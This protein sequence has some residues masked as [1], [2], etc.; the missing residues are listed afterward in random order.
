[1]ND[2]RTVILDHWWMNTQDVSLH[3][4]HDTV[5]QL[6]CLINLLKWECKVNR[7]HAIYVSQWD[8]L[9]VRSRSGTLYVYSDIFLFLFK[10]WA[11]REVK[12][13]QRHNQRRKEEGTWIYDWN[14]HHDL[15]WL[16]CCS[17]T[18]LNNPFY[19]TCDQTVHKYLIV[20]DESS[21]S[22]EIF[23]LHLKMYQRFV[24]CTLRMSAKAAR[25]SKSGLSMPSSGGRDY[26]VIPVPSH[27]ST[28]RKG[29]VVTSQ[30]SFRKSHTVLQKIIIYNKYI[31]KTLRS[32][33]GSAHSFRIW[34]EQTSLGHSK[35]N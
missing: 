11:K 31:P 33:R 16:S 26:N 25:N 29:Q 5:T 28:G 10:L 1:M 32:V 22:R 3:P 19:F 17:L 27:G 9:S 20:Q 21:Y 35:C 4:Q 6:V 18:T 24:S 12:G 2:V 23:I 15:T 14:T 13:L 30:V 8:I 7:S 34:N